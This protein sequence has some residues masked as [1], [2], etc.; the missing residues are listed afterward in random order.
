LFEL[1][2]NEEVL[3]SHGL[4]VT[5]RQLI[6]TIRQ[7]IGTLYGDFGLGSVAKSLQL[8][9]FN[10]MTRTGLLAVKRCHHTIVL[11]SLPFIRRVHHLDCILRTIHMSGTI[12]GCLKAL[13]VHHNKQIIRLRKQRKSSAI[14]VK[15]KSFEKAFKDI[16][17][18]L[19]RQQMPE[20]TAHT[21]T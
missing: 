1:M 5:E 12:R 20:T 15:M 3:D 21:K 8:K 18:S 9:R 10:D 17:S 4:G 6:E 13:R 19:L 7:T 14:G 16:E 11:T 2:P